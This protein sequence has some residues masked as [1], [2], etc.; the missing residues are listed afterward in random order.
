MKPVQ[1]KRIRQILRA[2]G[3]SMV[4]TEGSHEKWETPGGL[5]DTIVGH[6]REQSPGLLRNIQAVFEPEFGPKWLEK[7]LQR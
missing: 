3:C 7:E 6:D 2:K 4:G 5:T 1:T